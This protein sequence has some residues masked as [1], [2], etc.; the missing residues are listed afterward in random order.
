MALLFKEV[1]SWMH[2]FG[3]RLGT[4]AHFGFLN[5]QIMWRSL[6]TR[7]D[8]GILTSCFLEAGTGEVGI[9]TH[10]DPGATQKA[11]VTTRQNQSR[12]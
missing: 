8:S 4:S 9:R 10:V 1:K 6:P 12:R 3:F 11:E 5:V 2:P 7:S